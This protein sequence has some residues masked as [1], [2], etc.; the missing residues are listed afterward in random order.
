MMKPFEPCLNLQLRK[1]NRVMSQIYDA[2]LAPVGIKTSQFSILRAI[3][4][5]HMT[6]NRQLQ[7]ALILDQTSLTRALK[8]LIRDGYIVVSMNA[9][10]RR[11]K[12]LV[13]STKGNALLAAALDEW[14]KAQ[15]HVSERL[16]DLNTQAI[17]DIS[18]AVVRL[19][20]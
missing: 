20:G 17:L 4:Y 6:T 8:P 10:D 19:K 14:N 5:F 3:D 2:Y 1:A 9:E 12:Q 13:L 11:Q 15:A 18:E 7:E 16:G